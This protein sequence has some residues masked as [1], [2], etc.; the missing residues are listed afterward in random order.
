MFTTA[1]ED[2]VVM[3]SAVILRASEE[4]GLHTSIVHIS[5]SLFPVYFLF[6]FHRSQSVYG[7]DFFW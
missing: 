7:G 2:W 3:H 4:K 5:L 6:L 1:R